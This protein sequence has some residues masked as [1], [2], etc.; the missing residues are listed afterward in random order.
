VPADRA[1]A[2]VLA[3]REAGYP[4]TAI[5]GRVLPMGDALEPITIVA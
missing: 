2:C 3:L 5:I 1:D 4:R